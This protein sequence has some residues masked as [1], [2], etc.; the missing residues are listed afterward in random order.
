M[1]VPAMPAATTTATRCPGCGSD[2]TIWT[3]AATQHNFLCKTCG[4]CWH[5]APGMADRV[6]PRGCPG[7]GLRRICLAACC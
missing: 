6:D 3:Q 1:T 7:C 5:P 4:T 2:R